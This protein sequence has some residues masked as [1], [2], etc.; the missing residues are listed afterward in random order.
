MALISMGIYVFKKSVLADVL[1]HQCATGIGHDFGRDV[2]PSLL[3]T[4]RVF[5]YDFRDEKQDAPHYWRD[6]GTL[7]SYYDTSMDLIQPFPQF[8]PYINESQPSQPARHPAWRHELRARVH[9]S[10]RV[11]QSVLSPGVHIEGGADIEGSILMPGVRV[12]RG[13]RLRRTIVEE[14]VDIPAGFCAGLDTDRDRDRYT[15]TSRGVVV[16][17]NPANHSKL[18]FVRPVQRRGQIYAVPR[19]A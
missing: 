16:V 14:G 9:T 3:Q 15:V 1:H 4:H 17:G 11:A 10:S 5:A 12:G 19:T 2:I 7:D 13:A 6:I 8:D 18:G